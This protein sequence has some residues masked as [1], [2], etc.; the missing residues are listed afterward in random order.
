LRRFNIALIGP[1]GVGKTTQARILTAI[2]DLQ[3]ISPGDVLRDAV[4][5]GHATSEVALALQTGKLVPDVAVLDV[6]AGQLREGSYRG[7]VLDGHPRT[8]RQAEAVDDLL[9]SRGEML[10]AVIHLDTAREVA[11]AR[12]MGRAN[13]K[14]IDDSAAAR[15]ARFEE[16]C[17]VTLPLLGRYAHIVYRVDATPEIAEVTRRLIELLRGVLG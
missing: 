13:L 2:I 1:P 4:A 17:R 8:L 7:I 3:L 16:F 5:S 11:E 9:A 6:V 15:A 10:N 12:V 14:R